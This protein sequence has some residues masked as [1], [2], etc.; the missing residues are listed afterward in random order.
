MYYNILSNIVILGSSSPPDCETAG[1][2][3]GNC[4]NEIAGNPSDA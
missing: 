4:L 2:N 1:I 3:K